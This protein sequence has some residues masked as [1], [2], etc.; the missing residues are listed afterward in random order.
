MKN[1]T[2]FWYS[3]LTIMV[4]ILIYSFYKEILPFLLYVVT[5]VTI[6][7]IIA[8]FLYILLGFF[9]SI[10]SHI[11]NSDFSKEYYSKESFTDNYGAKYNIIYFL[12]YTC[13][14]KFNNWLN[15]LNK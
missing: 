9:L 3:V 1:S 15:N 12:L 10:T 5:S 7:L 8:I 14:V 11:T 6:I 13:V 2:K 4:L